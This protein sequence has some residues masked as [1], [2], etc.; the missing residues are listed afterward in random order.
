MDMYYVVKEMDA[1]ICSYT[2]MLIIFNIIKYLLQ[3]S[4]KTI[5]QKKSS[6]IILTWVTK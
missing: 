5:I 2:F 3:F 4:F 6:I 1:K